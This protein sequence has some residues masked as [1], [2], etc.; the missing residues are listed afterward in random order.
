MQDILGV[1]KKQKFSSDALL[2]KWNTI[3]KKYG[4]GFVDFEIIRVYKRY[5]DL[6]IL[7]EEERKKAASFITEMQMP[8]LASMLEKKLD[9]FI[10][11]L[12]E[13]TEDEKGQSIIRLATKSIY[14]NIQYKLLDIMEE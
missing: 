14:D 8:D 9:N 13:M 3:S 1:L 5:I 10:S 6:D 2:K 12:N 4:I 11:V 7:D